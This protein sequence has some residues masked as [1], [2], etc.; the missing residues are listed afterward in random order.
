VSWWHGV[1]SLAN[2]AGG[3]RYH[4]RALRHRRGCWRPFVAALGDWLGGWRAAADHLVL[5]GPSA[6][7]CLPETALA[8]FASLTGLEPDPLAR[9]LFVRRFPALAPRLRWHTADYLAPADGDF[10]VE[11]LRALVRD[12][13]AHAFLFCNVLGQLPYLHPAAAARPSF[14]LWKRALAAVLAD[15][16]FASFHDRLSGACVARPDALGT[17]LAVP[18]ATAELAERYL[19]AGADPVEVEDHDTGDLFPG[20]T[21]TLLAWEITPGWTHLV[22]AVRS[23]GTARGVRPPTD[24]EVLG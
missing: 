5:V 17:T 7:W 24:A 4:W 8:R 1:G 18:L 11:R 15:R 23:D 16:P 14:G 3:L 6:G 20:R 12:F 10:S 19:V 22:E 13:P 2:P 9:H 21:R